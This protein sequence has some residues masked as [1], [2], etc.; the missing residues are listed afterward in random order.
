MTVRNTQGR[1]TIAIDPQTQYIEISNQVRRIT[2]GTGAVGAY[3][4]AG[5]PNSLVVKGT[6]RKQQGP[7]GVAIEQPAAFFGYMLAE[8][9]AANGID[10]SGQLIERA[11]GPEVRFRLI[12]EC[13]TPLSLCLQRCNKDSFNLA[14]EALLKTVAA[15]GTAQRSQGSWAQGRQRVQAYL[16]GLGVSALECHVDDGS[17]LSRDN[18]LSARAL[19][20]VLRSVYRSSTWDFYSKTLAVGGV[21]GTLYRDFKETKY[22]GRIIGKSGYLTGVRAF[23]GVA[24]ADNGD[25]I[26][27]ILANKASG[28][29]Q[30]VYQM[31]KA[32]ID[33]N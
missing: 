9:L 13:R 26:F 19:T 24:R 2:S 3:R 29:K 21:D 15:H 5:H 28:V 27:S 33:C 10:L 32:I 17:G 7:F 16:K 11:L 20:T 30:I 31:A 18:R 8:Q 4:K 25:Y 12:S 22:Q 14:A 6:C 23:S 1:I